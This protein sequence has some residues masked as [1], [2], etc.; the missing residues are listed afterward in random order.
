MKV[1]V[2]GSGVVGTAC[3]YQLQRAGH[4]VVVVDR[5]SAPGLET[6]YANAGQVSWGYASPWAAPGLLRNAARWMWQAHSPLVLRPRLDPAQW[7]WLLAMLGNARRARYTVN[8]T[9]M[10]RLAR[11]SFRCLQDI[12]QQTGIRY[13]EAAH[14]TLQLYRDAAGL[15]A[16]AHELPML[17]HE[18]IRAQLLD[19]KGVLEIEP[20]L[21]HSPAKFVGGIRFPDD[22]TGDAH[23]FTQ[24]L[25]DVARRAGV[26]FRFN[27]T[28][29]R[30]IP[31]GNMI[32]EIV[33]D[34]GSD[35]ADAFVLA[36]GSFS[37][38][39]GRPLGINLPIYPVKGYSATLTLEDETAGPVS[40]L[41]D[42]RYKVAITRLGNRLRA[43]GIAEVSG[44][45][46]AIAP[47]REQALQHVIRELFPRAA[48]HARPQ[49]WAGLRPMTPDNVPL[50]GPTLY[51]NLYLNTGHGTLGWTMSN[52]SARVV[53][54]LISGRTPEIELDGLTLARFS[55]NQ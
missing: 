32:R 47:A 12:R 21:Q 35:T 26:T 22:E 38:S 45:G 46:L 43:A 17:E 30:L 3:A 50:L 34:K 27:T 19:R 52:G 20:G 10:L 29:H 33:T 36:A 14:G 31:H 13:D 49:F 53:A 44:Y 11:Y 28:V 15:A 51:E 55:A 23:L 37:P 40:T 1:L 2:I 39:L 8:K 54:D 6:S 48:P 7:R 18:G 42:E 41:T 25:A 5:Q 4:D 24:G 16:A 9:R